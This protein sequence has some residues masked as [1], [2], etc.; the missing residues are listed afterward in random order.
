MK[1]ADT[2]IL[3][4]PA[5]SS[6]LEGSLPAVEFS[7]AEHPPNTSAGQ[8]SQRGQILSSGY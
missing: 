4:K 1:K 8:V 7:T 5:G 6:K 3:L 2:L